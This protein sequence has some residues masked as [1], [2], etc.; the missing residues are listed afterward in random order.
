MGKLNI[1][2]GVKEYVKNKNSVL[3]DVRTKEEY[4]ERHIA[5]SLNMPV[6]SLENVR[7]RIVNKATPIYVYCHSGVRSARA[8]QALCEMGYNNVTDIGGI[9]DYADD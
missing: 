7:L 6:Q 2:D 9:K 8:A 3:L 4:N 5:G 1:N